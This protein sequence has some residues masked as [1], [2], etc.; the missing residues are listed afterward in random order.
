MSGFGLLSGRLKTN[1]PVATTRPCKAPEPA[2]STN[3]AS[4]AAAAAPS[5]PEKTKAIISD[6]VTLYTT[7][8]K[9]PLSF[10]YEVASTATKNVKFT[11]N[12]NGSVNFA[13]VDA[14]G[15]AVPN[16]T[17]VATIPPAGKGVLG[18]VSL[19]DTTKG[20]R[21]E[22][23]YDWAYEEPDPVKVIN[24]P[25]PNPNTH[26]RCAHS[27]PSPPPTRAVDVLYCSFLGCAGQGRC[28][29]EREGHR[30][31]GQAGLRVRRQPLRGPG[32]QGRQGVAVLRQPGPHRFRLRVRRGAA[33]RAS[34]V[35]PPVGD[36][37]GAFPWS[38]QSTQTVVGTVRAHS[39][40]CPHI[41]SL[42]SSPPLP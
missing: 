36:L 15:K 23:E 30:G 19:A 9:E 39:L 2:P 32:F 33:G 41:V 8:T 7:K 35:V 16:L 18:T 20:A 17:M 14:A 38:R 25:A 40:R 13:A 37:Q 4:G 28:G 1:R 3:A 11:M 26:A 31:A 21:L 42:F 27:L 22:V 6:E 24:R 5:G 29:E 34:G 12:F 10:Q